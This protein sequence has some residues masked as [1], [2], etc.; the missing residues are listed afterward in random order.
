MHRYDYV[1]RP[2]VEVIHHED[3]LRLFPGRTEANLVTGLYATRSVC[4]S[5]T[6][7]GTSLPRSWPIPRSWFHRFPPI[8]FDFFRCLLYS[9]FTFPELIA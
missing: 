8:G 3:M 9:L 7:V 4:A 5:D 2:I 6:A 1:R